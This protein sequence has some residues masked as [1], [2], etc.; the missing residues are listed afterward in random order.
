LFA[1]VLDS[2]RT[3][4]QTKRVC[5]L[6]LLLR[7]MGRSKHTITFQKHGSLVH[8]NKHGK[9]GKILHRYK[10]LFGTLKGYFGD[11]QVD[12]DRK[13]M[14][15]RISNWIVQHGLDSYV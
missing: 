11:K 8:V 7:A 12:V 2:L 1:S 6:P 10:I 3:A 13:M 15:K 14:Y 4:T 9:D 5:H